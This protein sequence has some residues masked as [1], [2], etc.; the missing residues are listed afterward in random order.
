LA[1]LW[2]ELWPVVGKY[3]VNRIYWVHG[4]AQPYSVIEHVQI[5]TTDEIDT[6][7]VLMNTTSCCWVLGV[8][9]G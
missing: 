2:P 1:W 4:S 3:T 6:Y 8:T 5:G 7:R 9:G